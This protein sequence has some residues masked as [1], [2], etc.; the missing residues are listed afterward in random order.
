MALQLKHPGATHI[1]CA[2]SLWNDKYKGSDNLD[3]GDHG[4][5][6][7]LLKVIDQSK[8]HN[9]CLFLV[10]YYHGTKLGPYRFQ[11]FSRLAQETINLVK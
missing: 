7:Q 6:W 10:R 5:S 8:C 4:G 9:I 3:D 1:M 2:Y 11:I